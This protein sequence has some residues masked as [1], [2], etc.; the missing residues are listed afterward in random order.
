M[1]FFKVLLGDIDNLLVKAKLLPA[2][3]PTTV[4]APS[5]QNN[6][7]KPNPS[8][9]NLNQGAITPALP[10]QTIPPIALGNSVAV[11]SQSIVVS[12]TGIVY[13]EANNQVA[14]S[15]VGGITKPFAGAAW[16][17]PKAASGAVNNPQTQ[18]DP[19][20]GRYFTVPTSDFS[21][22]PPS[23]AADTGPGVGSGV[24]AANKDLTSNLPPGISSAAPALNAVLSGAAAV[25]QPFDDLGMALFGGSQTGL[26]MSNPAVAAWEGTQPHPGR[27]PAPQNSI[28]VKGSV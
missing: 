28:Q 17:P 24:S 23:I 2:P 18:N 5:S 8:V 19:G 11:G 22:V 7:P 4:P 14:G 1:S 16:S 21:A 25:A 6:L 13:P 15:T 27:T 12:A 3:K 20:S 26:D 10:T 9:N